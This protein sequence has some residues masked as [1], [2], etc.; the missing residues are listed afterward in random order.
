MGKSNEKEEFWRLVIEEHGASGLSVRAFC[1]REGVSEPSFYAWRKRL[2][3]RDDARKAAT[4]EQGQSL[5]RVDIVD[6]EQQHPSKA[7]WPD[8]NLGQS[9]GGQ[10]ATLE[11]LTPCGFTVRVSET[12]Q[13]T[14]LATLLRAIVGLDRETA[15]G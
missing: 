4:T 14:R 12:V 15:S 8:E 9:Y 3:D 2:R 11:V 10:V 13:P 7:K 5:V 1:E 6:P